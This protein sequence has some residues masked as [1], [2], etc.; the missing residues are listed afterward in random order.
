M[1]IYALRKCQNVHTLSQHE[2]RNETSCKTAG[3]IYCENP[4]WE[5]KNQ[6]TWHPASIPTAVPYIALVVINVDTWGSTGNCHIIIC[7]H[8]INW[9][10][11]IHHLWWSCR[12]EIRQYINIALSPDNLAVWALVTKERGDCGEEGEGYEGSRIS[13]LPW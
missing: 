2:T 3:F 13:F 9:C 5:T 11:H 4:Y 10:Y 12:L 1:P 6:A 7:N 8:Y